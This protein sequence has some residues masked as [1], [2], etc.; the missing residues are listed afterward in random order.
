MTSREIESNLFSFQFNSKRDMDKVLSIEPWHFNKQVLILCK[1]KS[2][3]Q[4]S[5]MVLNTIPFWIRIY[6]I[7]LVGHDR[8]TMKQIGSKLGEF[9]E[10]DE[11]TLGGLSRSVCIKVR[12]NLE[13]PLKRGIKIHMDQSS[14]KWLPVKYERLFSFCYEYGKLGHLMKDC[15]LAED[16]DFEEKQDEESLPFGDW[17]RASPMKQVRV[18]IDEGTFSKGPHHKALFCIK[19]NTNEC[20]EKESKESPNGMKDLASMADLMTNI[21]KVELNPNLNP[22]FPK[23]HR[24]N[25]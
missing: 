10:I 8:D 13:A 11:A 9:M 1:V 20:S 7:P 19:K 23:H 5:A 4:P 24:N 25:R 17:L 6:D 2:E 22:P 15:G 14:L 3:V 16:R 18:V 12:I 21:Q